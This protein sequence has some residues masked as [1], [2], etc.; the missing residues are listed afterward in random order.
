MSNIIYSI[1]LQMVL[2]K[3]LNL[4]SV[5]QEQMSSKHYVRTVC[6]FPHQTAPD[7]IPGIRRFGTAYFAS[8]HFIQLMTHHI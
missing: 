7:E 2:C 3:F 6:S 1:Q 8:N 5:F 4:H